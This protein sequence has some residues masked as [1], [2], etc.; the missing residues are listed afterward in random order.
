MR[1]KSLSYILFLIAAP[2]QASR[3]AAYDY[4]LTTPQFT[5]DGRLLQ[6]EYAAK[7]C[8]REG[9]NPILS[10]GFCDEN[11]VVLVMATISSDVGVEVDDES[12]S[13]N[14]I[15]QNAKA[16][17]RIIEVPVSAFYSHLSGSINPISAIATSSIL[18]GLSGHLSDAASLLQ[19]I[20]SQ[21]EEEQSV[22]GWHRLGISP[23]GQEIMNKS[24]TKVSTIETALRL[25]Y[26]SADLCQKHAFGGGQRPIGASLLL[27][28]GDIQQKSGRIVMCRTDPSGNL[29]NLVSIQKNGKEVHVPKIMIS[30]GSSKSQSKLQLTIDLWLKE[31]FSAESTGIEKRTRQVLRAAVLSLMEE[32]RTRQGSQLLECTDKSN[33]SSNLPQMEVVFVSSKMGSFRLSEED[34]HALLKDSTNTKPN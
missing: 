21:L 7:A 23:T 24:S 15:R 12:S 27:C 28:A 10:V 1:R 31:L 9:S 34:V 6:V 5:P 4:D 2:V 18:I 32:W 3:Y 25:A 20:Y 19:T 8:V 22:F 13:S 16:Q 11:D 14:E 26:V 29:H 30:G 33:E 17:Y